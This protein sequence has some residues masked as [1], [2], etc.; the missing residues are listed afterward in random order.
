MF[1]FLNVLFCTAAVL[2][3]TSEDLA[4]AILEERDARAAAFE[5]D[6]A[7]WRGHRFDTDLL[8]R[9]REYMA[10]FGSCSFREP[11]DDLRG[12]RLL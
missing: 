7:R 11:M 4:L 8:E 2:G 9:A 6:G 1:G 3:G 10:A 5:A 12:A